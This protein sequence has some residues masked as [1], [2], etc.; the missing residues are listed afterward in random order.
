MFGFMHTYQHTDGNPLARLLEYYYYDP[1][2]LVFNNRMD[3]CW[4]II[5]GANFSSNSILPDMRVYEKID[6]NSY[7][8]LV[9][10]WDSEEMYN[11]WFNTTLNDTNIKV[12]DDWIELAEVIGPP[13]SDM[14][15]VTQTHIPPMEGIHPGVG[16]VE[17][18]FEE[19]LWKYLRTKL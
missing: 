3:I 4:G 12:G 5:F 14:F 15:G 2:G 16:M 6:D 18:P 17:M 13:I 7:N 9:W 19:I 10:S 8:E 1:V 11:D